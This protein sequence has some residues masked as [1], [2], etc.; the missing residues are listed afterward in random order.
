MISTAWF[1]G[2]YGEI[3]GAALLDQLTL[4]PGHLVLVDPIADR[5]PAAGPT[6]PAG[7]ERA[8]IAPP[9]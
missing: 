5:S 6:D 9:P 7:P 4:D 3:F 1:A 8:N 2:R